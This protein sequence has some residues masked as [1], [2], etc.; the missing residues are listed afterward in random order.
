MEFNALIILYLKKVSSINHFILKTRFKIKPNIH[1]SYAFE[2]ESNMKDKDGGHKG[3]TI[4]RQ[5]TPQLSSLP[6]GTCV[7]IAC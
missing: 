6:F 5:M 7:G 1:H 3:N 2:D 4:N